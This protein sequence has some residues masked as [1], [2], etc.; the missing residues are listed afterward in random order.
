M[1]KL[2]III[3]LTTKRSV[4]HI[5]SQDKWWIQGIINLPVSSTDQSA[6]L[7]HLYLSQTRPTCAH[8]ISSW[9]RHKSWC[10]LS[11]PVNEWAAK[12]AK[13]KKS[14][15]KHNNSDKRLTVI[16]R[17]TFFVI[18]IQHISLFRL[19]AV[20]ISSNKNQDKPVWLSA[21]SLLHQ[22]ER[23]KVHRRSPTHR[24]RRTL[25]PVGGRLR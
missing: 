5:L 12:S 13:K 10:T 21:P 2:S 6:V 9:W 14:S 18:K 20:W 24:G 8:G 4:E 3:Q 19:E 23:T 22:G 7:R 16:L 11:S 17:V 25:G 15:M 1:R